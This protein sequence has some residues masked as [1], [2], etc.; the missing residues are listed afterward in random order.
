[1]NAKTGV[2][3]RFEFDLS[4][5]K[6]IAVLAA[7]FMA[8]NPLYLGSEQLSIST[9]YP[10]PFGIYSK[11]KV[12]QY[13][14]AVP[15]GPSPADSIIRVGKLNDDPFFQFGLE[16]RHGNDSTG[17]LVISAENV[18]DTLDPSAR[19][20]LVANSNK[21]VLTNS[22]LE[23]ERVFFGNACHFADYSFGVNDNGLFS[24]YCNGTGPSSNERQ[25]VFGAY[26]V[27]GNMV[28]LSSSTLPQSGKIL[29][30]R[31]ETVQ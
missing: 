23:P 19:I 2:I 31:I 13:L 30:C 14:D 17:F 20:R 4:S 5:G 11:L 10:A 16:R 3:I 21:I 26:D 27:D 1:M 28:N 6:I 22:Y 18:D 12:A 15:Y 29:C 8:L 9:Y 24:S 7:V 25:T